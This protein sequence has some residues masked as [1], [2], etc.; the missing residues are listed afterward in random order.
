MKP[1]KSGSLIWI[2]GLPGAGKSTLAREVYKLLKD[3]R[4]T[5]LMDGDAFREVMG[6]D[7]GY[8]PEDRRKNAFRLARMNKYLVQH[9][10]TVVCATV[11]LYK[12]VHDWNREHIEHLVEVFIEVPKDILRERDQ[13]GLYTKGHSGEIKDVIG[14]HQA[15]DIPENAHMIIKNSGDLQSLLNHASSIINHIS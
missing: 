7:L 10:I 12:D 14:I 3:V 8:S 1:L 2:T 5:V 13:K 11:S 15:Y 6:N 9:G 4:P